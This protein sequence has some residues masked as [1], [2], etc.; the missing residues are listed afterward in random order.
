[1]GKTYFIV[2]CSLILGA[3]LA[4]LPTAAGT[5]VVVALVIA[6]QALSIHENSRLNR[7]LA[8]LSAMLETKVKVQTME[9]LRR[10]RPEAAPLP[11][12]ERPN[13]ADEPV[14]GLGPFHHG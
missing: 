5:M 7:E 12:G 14:G 8:E 2:C 13:G 6:R 9:M 1:M 4:D 11:P 10:G 3:A